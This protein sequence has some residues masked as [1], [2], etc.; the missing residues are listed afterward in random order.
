VIVVI[1]AAQRGGSNMLVIRRHTT[2]PKHAPAV[3]RRA[4]VTH[5]AQ[6]IPVT[7]AI[8]LALVT[9]SLMA[10]LA[11]LAFT[12]LLL[13]LVAPHFNAFQRSVDAR[14]EQADR[15]AAIV[16][17]ATLLSR[18]SE[19]QRVEFEELERLTLE[20][21]ERSRLTAHADAAP[22]LAIER[23]LGLDRLLVSYVRLAVAHRR[24][25]ESFGVE[26]R[27][28]LEAQLTRLDAVRPSS[29][30]ACASV[31]RQ[32]GILAARERT[33][34]RARDERE[35]FAHELATIAN[36]IRWVHELCALVPRSTTEAEIDE[37]LATVES[38]H[39]A[40]A[41]SIRDDETDAIDPRVLELGRDASCIAPPRYSA[42]PIVTEPQLPCQPLFDAALLSKSAAV[43][44]SPTRCSP[45]IP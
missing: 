9:L 6:L 35:V 10:T 36:V 28:A 7:L 15:A 44:V 38:E 16:A 24:N 4:A 39:A 22:E 27:A 30:R 42:V 21:R 41:D 33:W 34:A 2:K 12:E 31:E 13:I 1:L 29:T 5:F 19:H 37:V 45:A 32:R 8:G 3:Y 18:L 23:W 14:F 11:V 17:R 40:L 20:V 43:I 25:A 26:K